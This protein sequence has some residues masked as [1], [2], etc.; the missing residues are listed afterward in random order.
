MMLASKTFHGIGSK[1]KLDG[2]EDNPL[3]AELDMI[4]P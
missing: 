1:K 4:S 2:G 3:T